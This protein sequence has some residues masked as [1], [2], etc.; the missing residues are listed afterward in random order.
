MKSEKLHD[1]WRSSTPYNVDVLGREL[2]IVA[3]PQFIIALSII[4]PASSNPRCVHFKN[5]RNR[6]AHR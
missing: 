6:I 2:H 5:S 3:P 1:G 4:L